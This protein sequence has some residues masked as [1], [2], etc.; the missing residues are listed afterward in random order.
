MG[1]AQE[2][3]E[4]GEV[5]WG[6]DRAE[7]TPVVVRESGEAGGARDGGGE[8]EKPEGEEAARGG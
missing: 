8:G 5:E 3:G 6:G 4:V 1:G 2:G 7:D